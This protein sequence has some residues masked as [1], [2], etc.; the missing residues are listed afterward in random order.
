MHGGVAGAS[1][2]STQKH[3]MCNRSIEED[4]CSRRQEEIEP[5]AKVFVPSPETSK[6]IDETERSAPPHSP[7]LQ[8]LWPVSYGHIIMEADLHC[9]SESEKGSEG[10]GIDACL[11]QLARQVP[12]VEENKMGTAPAPPAGRPAHQLPRQTK[13]AHQTISNKVVVPLAQMVLLEE[14]KREEA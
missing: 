13:G 2:Q 14:K 4:G 9:S 1:R 6:E 11:P 3:G 8:Q 12:R 10:R 5:Q 7:L